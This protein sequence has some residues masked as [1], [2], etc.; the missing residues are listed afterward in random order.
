[1]A[2]MLFAE[3]N[4]VKEQIKNIA[5]NIKQNYP[6]FL[7]SKPYKA[8]EKVIKKSNLKYFLK[9]DRV[10]VLELF[11]VKLYSIDNIEKDFSN[12]DKDVIFYIKI[13]SLQRK[14]KRINSRISRQNR[15][16]NSKTEMFARSLQTYICDY[17]KCSKIAPNVTNIY[18]EIIA[19]K[20]IKLLNDF[21]RI[22][23]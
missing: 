7:L 19:S 16:Y 3:K 2:K 10:K 4:M 9:Y 11:S 14:L 6:D 18:N 1:T 12:I 20:K 8:F 13:K 5:N 21:Y 15:Y 17:E 23:Q 22:C